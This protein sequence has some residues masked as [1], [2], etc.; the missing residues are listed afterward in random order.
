MYD[1]NL[2]GTVAALWLG[3]MALLTWHA[4]RYRVP[5]AIVGSVAAWLGVWASGSRT[6]FMAAAI[7]TAAIGR[8]VFDHC[9]QSNSFRGWICDRCNKVLG[10]VKDSVE[11]LNK[12]GTYLSVRHH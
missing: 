8:I 10:L 3:G 1:A 6:A 7:V 9:H 5:L 12:M 11:L 4:K 2:S